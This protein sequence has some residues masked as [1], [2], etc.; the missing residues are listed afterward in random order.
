MD[1]LLVSEDDN[2]I[3]NLLESRSFLLIRRKNLK[4]MLYFKKVK[5]SVHVELF[6]NPKKAY[7]WVYQKKLSSSQQKDKQKGNLLEIPGT[8]AVRTIL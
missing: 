3:W 1:Y 5:S 2:L 6:A 8:N 7:H 4:L